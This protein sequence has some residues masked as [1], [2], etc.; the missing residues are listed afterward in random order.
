[1]VVARAPRNGLEV[2]VTSGVA[3]NW[4]PI[5]RP[6]LCTLSLRT[7]LSAS[8]FRLKSSLPIREVLWTV[9]I[10]KSHLPPQSSRLNSSLD[11]HSIPHILPHR[12]LL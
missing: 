7:A 1:M 5:Q 9:S 2:K 12:P 10:L 8:E 4:Y 11:F 3:P 6:P